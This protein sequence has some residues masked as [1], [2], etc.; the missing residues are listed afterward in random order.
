MDFMLDKISW[1]LNKFSGKI[2]IPVIP[3]EKLNAMME[4][5]NPY[6]ADANVIFPVDTIIQITLINMG[7]QAVMLL[8][9]T[10][11]FVRKMLPF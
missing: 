1:L 2:K 3:W 8:I 10:I 9:W 11:T 4:V 7:I 6:L 5:V